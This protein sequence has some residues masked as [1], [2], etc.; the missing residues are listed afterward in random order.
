MRKRKLQW[1]G[2]A[3]PASLLLAVKCHSATSYP[4]CW[5]HLQSNEN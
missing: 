1:H 2:G 4:L 3:R 5:R